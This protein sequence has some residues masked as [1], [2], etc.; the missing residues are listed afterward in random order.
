MR[1]GNLAR[2]KVGRR[3]LIIRQHLPHFL[4]IVS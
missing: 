4:G 2:L 1:L 3:Q